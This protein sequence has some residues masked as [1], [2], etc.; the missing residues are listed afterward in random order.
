M[1]EQDEQT[2]P[3]GQPRVVKKVVK[4]TVVR[5]PSASASRTSQPMGS[6][7]TTP[8][9]DDAGTATTG[10]A[11][12]RS[13][14]PSIDLGAL[15]RTGRSLGERG[16]SGISAVGSAV[17]GVGSATGQRLSDA[18]WDVRTYRLPPQ[19][20]VRAAVVVGLL[21]GGF[22]LLVGWGSAQLFTELR[23]TSAGGGLWGGLVVLALALFSGW[24]GARLLRA[25]SVEHAGGISGLAVLLVLTAVLMFFVDL[26]AGGWALLI[27]PTLGA[28]AY[29]GAAVLIG[30]AAQ[31]TQTA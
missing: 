18:F 31:D 12:L 19:P 14:R 10:D 9:A 26:A 13:R 23:G 28:V 16:G 25:A 2:T 8:P 15:R 6:L 11:P 21:L 24:L 3:P 5:P 7:R 29:A 22:S 4:R 1:S 27:M 30:L 17:R 20:T